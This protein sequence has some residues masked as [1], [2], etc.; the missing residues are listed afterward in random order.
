MNASGKHWSHRRRRL[1]TLA[2]AE[3]ALQLVSTIMFLA[4]NTYLIAHECG[5][6]N[7]LVAWS[8]FVRWVRSSWRVRPPGR[9]EGRPCRL[10]PHCHATGPSCILEES[11]VNLWL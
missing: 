2:S 4:P 6:F 10:P 8:A 9:H 7:P 3:L 5:W 1:A 11:M